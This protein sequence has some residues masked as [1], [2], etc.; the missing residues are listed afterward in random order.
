MHGIEYGKVANGVW[1]FIAGGLC[2]GMD[3][4]VCAIPENF[5]D[6]WYGLYGIANF[7]IVETGCDSLT[8]RY[9]DLDGNELG[10]IVIDEEGG[11][12]QHDV[13]A[14]PER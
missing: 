3:E 1:S 8:V 11:L 2:G 13:V 14:P 4:E 6:P 5:P 9:M 7:T 10:R 12:L